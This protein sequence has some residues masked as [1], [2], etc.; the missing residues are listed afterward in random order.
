VLAAVIAAADRYS[1]DRRE[2]GR[3]FIGG[4]LVLPHCGIIF[5]GGFRK[6]FPYKV[7]V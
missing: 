2:R 6:Y 5:F 7:R 4:I 3:V 1:S